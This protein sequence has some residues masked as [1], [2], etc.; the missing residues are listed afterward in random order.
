MALQLFTFGHGTA[1]RDELAELLRGAG[2][3]RV[4]DVRPDLHTSGQLCGFAGSSRLIKAIWPP[5]SGH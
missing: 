3:E 5:P 1:G 4:V 2:I